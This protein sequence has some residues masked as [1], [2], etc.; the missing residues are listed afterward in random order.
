MISEK[1]FKLLSFL[2]EHPQEEFTQRKLA[3][4]LGL[5]LGKVNS[6]LKEMKEANWI[7]QEGHLSELGKE[8]LEPYRVQN[9]VIMAAGMSSRFAPLS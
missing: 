6:L 4:E 8:A 9:A 2:Q 1:Q 3:E 7:D 5:S